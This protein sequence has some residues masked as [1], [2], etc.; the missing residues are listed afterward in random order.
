MMNQIWLAMLLGGLVLAM[1]NGRMEQVTAALLQSAGD[2][3]TL[4]LTLLGVIS[5]WSGFMKI[6]QRSGLTLI[7]A[8]AARPLLNILFPR[9]KHDAAAMGAVTMNLA[10]NFLGLGNAATP[11]GLKAMTEL[12]RLNTG[13]H[14]V[15]NALAAGSIRRDAATDEMSMFLVLNTAFIQLVPSTIIALRAALGSKESTGITVAIWIASA[16]SSAVGITAAK[17]LSWRSRKRR[18]KCLHDAKK[19][20]GSSNNIYGYS[21]N[22]YGGRNGRY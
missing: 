6:A 17:L 21:K 16:C 19:I 5:L 4:C 8:K 22:L 20:H 12:Q 9:I 15:G 18:P 11:L 7:F 3:V 13:I 1:I 14:S 10:A 2:A